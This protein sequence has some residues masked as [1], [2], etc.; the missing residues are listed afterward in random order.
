MAC[1]RKPVDVTFLFVPFPAGESTAAPGEETT[2][3][4]PGKILNNMEKKKKD[5]INS[6]YLLLIMS[7]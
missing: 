3:V 4:S 6:C 1:Y 5:I 7:S 2:A